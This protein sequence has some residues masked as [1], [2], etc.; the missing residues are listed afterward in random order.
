MARGGDTSWNVTLGPFG[1]TLSSMSLETC[2]G[3]GWP[4]A[5]GKSSVSR[6]TAAVLAGSKEILTA[7]AALPGVADGSPTTDA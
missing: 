2:A 1:L 3:G 4:D 6:L 7:A 5:A